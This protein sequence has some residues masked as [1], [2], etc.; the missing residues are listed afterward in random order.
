MQLWCLLIIIY[1]P[2]S[3]VEKASN[4]H[5]QFSDFLVSIKNAQCPVFAWLLTWFKSGLLSSFQR[6]V[7][8]II[9]FFQRRTCFFS[10]SM[11]QKCSCCERAAGLS[12][13]AGHRGHFQPH[14]LPQAGCGGPGVPRSP[15]ALP[16]WRLPA[17]SHTCSRPLNSF[18]RK[19]S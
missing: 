16:L 7:D 12:I 15:R 8:L 5:K 19:T 13:P 18:M 11:A 3:A 17:C 4:A 2:V 6:T 10:V 9:R 1:K 14:F